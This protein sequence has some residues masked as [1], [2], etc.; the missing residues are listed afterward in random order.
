MCRRPQLKHTSCARDLTARFATLVGS[1]VLA[2]ALALVTALPAYAAQDASL[3]LTMQYT[4]KGVTKP[5]SGVKATAYQVA[6]LDENINF[7]TLQPEFT[8]LDVDFNKG[9]DAETATKAANTAMQIVEKNKLKGTE[10]TSIA[11]GSLPF[12]QLP[13]GVYLVMQTGAT[14]TAEQ[15]NNF[16]PFL[17]SVPQLTANDIVYDVQVMPKT[18]LKPETPQV[19]KTPLAKT[20]DLIDPQLLA[21][22]FATGAACLLAGIFLRKV[23]VKRQS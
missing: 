7:Y 4:S 5:I 11:N 8:S 6:S 10:S 1:V 23:G 12:G 21:T 19:V 16:T 15:Y 3:L 13:Y 20:S 22:L 2:L 18:T 14:G 9:L 17:I